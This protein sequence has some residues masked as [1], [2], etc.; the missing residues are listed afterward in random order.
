MIKER[1]RGRA[2]GPVDAAPLAI[3][4]RVRRLVDDVHGGN[5]LEA[6]AYAGV[7]YSSL[8][9]I[10]AGRARAP[11]TG[12]L[13]RLARAY[14]LPLGW[15]TSRRYSDDGTVPLAGWIGFLPEGFETPEGIGSDGYRVT[16]PMAAWPLIR[17]L[18]QLEQRLTALPAGPSRPI[19]GSATDPRDIR[20][21]LAAFI[22]QPILAARGAG[23]RGASIGHPDAR[24]RP[25]RS[26]AEWSDML[27][28]LGRFWE[29]ALSDLM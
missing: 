14:E 10:H 16:V 28:D 21:R 11:G 13:E 6:S 24:P 19:I 5:L 9:E 27:R 12:M 17:V 20:R 23:L 2:S 18:A 3:T 26:I 8:R 25:S 15:F 29:R 22:F 1:R 4:T 7:P